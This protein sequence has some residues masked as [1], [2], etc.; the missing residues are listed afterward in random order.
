MFV[1]LI[2]R[3]AESS[4]ELAD[5]TVVA[6]LAEQTG[7][8]SVWP[9]DHLLRETFVEEPLYQ[10]L[11]RGRLRMVPRAIEE[12]PRTPGAEGHEVPSRLW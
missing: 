9:K 3:L 11:T 6:Y 2:A 5:R 10:W 7:P 4:V 1:A 8:D 12:H